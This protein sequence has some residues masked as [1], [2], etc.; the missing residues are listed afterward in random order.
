MESLFPHGI[1]QFS[2]IFHFAFIKFSFTVCWWIFLFWVVLYLIFYSLFDPRFVHFSLSARHYLRHSE[3]TD[4]ITNFI[5]PNFWWL[6]KKKSQNHKITFANRTPDKNYRFHFC[7][8]DLNC[9]FPWGNLC[10]FK[11]FLV[12]YFQFLS[13]HYARCLEFSVVNPLQQIS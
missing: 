7:V 11:L 9:Q 4:K 10:L 13:V 3:K 2:T 1:E 8:E 12:Q 5:C 6:R